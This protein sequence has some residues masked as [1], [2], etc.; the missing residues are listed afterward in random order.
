MRILE[1]LQSVIVLL[2]VGAVFAFVGICILSM[3]IWRCGND[4]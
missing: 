4:K 2:E 1:W 3:V